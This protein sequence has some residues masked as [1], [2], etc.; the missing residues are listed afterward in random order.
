MVHDLHHVPARVH[1]KG[2]VL[3]S[4]HPRGSLLASVGMS[5][6]VHLFTPDGKLLREVVA[7]GP[8]RALALGWSCASEKLAILQASPSGHALICIFHLRDQQRR[9]VIDLKGVRELRDPTCMKWSLTDS[10][11]LA[12]G[13]GK[14]VVYI[15]HVQNNSQEAIIHPVGGAGRVL[16]MQWMETRDVLSVA[17]EGD[18]TIRFYDLG[19]FGDG[20]CVVSIPCKHRPIS[21]RIAPRHR[22]GR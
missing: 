3:C 17:Y 10:E 1:G 4:W 11:L 21:M 16:W 5:R 18:R 15:H 6:V 20:R 7:P 14:G 8:N 19:T 22:W 9:E 12:I 2:P 13:T